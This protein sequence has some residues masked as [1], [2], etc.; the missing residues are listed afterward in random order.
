MLEEPLVLL[1]DHA[2]LYRVQFPGDAIPVKPPIDIVALLNFDQSY[3]CRGGSG[4]IASPSPTMSIEAQPA[5][6]QLERVANLFFDK[7]QELHL[8]QQRMLECFVS[9]GSQAMPSTIGAGGGLRFPVKRLPTI[10]FDS[11]KDNSS[12]VTVVS[13]TPPKPSLA[14]VSQS[15][16][17]EEPPAD[18]V[19]GPALAGS[20]ADPAS[21]HP[22]S[23]GAA[24]PLPA[25]GS[26]A[27]FSTLELLELLDEREAEKKGRVRGEV[28]A[29]VLFDLLT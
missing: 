29:L 11:D 16:R 14:V 1:R 21:P 20:P 28:A 24:V 5:S 10:S 18:A 17:N 19:P 13:T 2:E 27:R 23:P 25:G 15:P 9:G 22:A 3:G 12:V 8:S 7:M 4:K 26:G 6:G